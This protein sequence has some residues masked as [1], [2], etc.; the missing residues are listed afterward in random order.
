MVTNIGFV[1]G[2]PVIREGADDGELALV[3]GRIRVSNTVARAVAF[4]LERSVDG[5]VTWEQVLAETISG[6]G[7]N[8][9]DYESLSYGDTLY[10]AV[11]FTIEGATAE[12]EITVPA[13]SSALWL[14]GGP[15]YGITGRLP[16]DPQKKITAGRARSMKR[17]AGRSRPVA[18]VGEAT[19]RTVSISGT[20]N[21]LDAETASADRLAEIAQLPDRLFLFRD[22]DGRRIYGVIENIDLSWD[23]SDPHEGGYN[24]WWGY[25][26]T[27]TEAT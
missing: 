27:L 25:T 24:S 10:R 21:D 2:H 20:T 1:G 12:T 7:A 15:A 8:L 6:V 26:C 17:Y 5:G 16:F 9:V 13:R 18:V 4:T 22:P 19:T 23:K 3:G 14:S 11:A